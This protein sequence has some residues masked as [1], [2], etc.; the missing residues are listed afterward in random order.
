MADEKSKGTGLGEVVGVFALIILVVLVLIVLALPNQTREFFNGANAWVTGVFNTG[1]YTSLTIIS[2]LITLT[3]AGLSFWLFLRILDMEKSHEEHVYHHVH[4]EDHDIRQES[5]MAR[6]K[7]APPPVFLE[8]KVVEH[9]GRDAWN[10][11]LEY[12]VSKNH[13][14]WLLA[15]IE[16]DKILDTLVKNMGLPGDS[17]GERLKNTDKGLFKTL[18][19]AWEA[20]TMRNKIAHS[21][22]EVYLTEREMAHI[23]RLYEAVFKEFKYI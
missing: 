17:L 10:R 23:I 14:D 22:K 6:S 21:E 16:A 19:L 3:L 2:G 9:P 18:D 4:N 7:V 20:H 8:E 11:V 15:I 5:F 1:T 12:V 13:S